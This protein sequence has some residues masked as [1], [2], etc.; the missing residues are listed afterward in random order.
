MADIFIQWIFF[1]EN[2]SQSSGTAH[3]TMGKY[4]E[5]NYSAHS[6]NQYIN[7]CT[8]KVFSPICKH[9][10]SKIRLGGIYLSNFHP[11]RVWLLPTGQIHLSSIWQVWIPVRAWWWLPSLP[12]GGFSCCRSLSNN[13][14]FCQ[15][16]SPI[17]PT[18]HGCLTWRRNASLSEEMFS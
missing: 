14:F 4:E 16:W 10:R 5:L 3:S 18:R 11:Q 17:F 1:H 12:R 9:E 8:R 15:K 6:Q 7:Y 2:S 13:T